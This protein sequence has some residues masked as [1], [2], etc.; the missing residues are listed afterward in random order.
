M[1]IN[2]TTKINRPG[3]N[4]D[5]LENVTKRLKTDQWKNVR[6]DDRRKAMDL[7]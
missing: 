1:L 5:G 2:A 4:G 3:R 6:G 7:V